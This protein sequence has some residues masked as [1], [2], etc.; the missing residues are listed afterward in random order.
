MSG[1]A[2]S[3]MPAN[4][5]GSREAPP[6]EA[7]LP[8]G[9]PEGARCLRG[10]DTEGAHYLV[11]VPAQW[12]GHLVVHAHGG[13]PLGDPKPTRVDEDVRRW[14]AMVRE[15]HAWAGSVFR[16]G[17]FAVRS[18]AEDTERVRRIFTEHVATPRRTLLHGQSWGAMVAAKAAEL[19][20]Q[21]WD[22]LLLSSGAVGGLLAYDF[23]LDL[24]A[25]YQYLCNNHPR[26]D[27]PAYPLSVGLRADDPMTEA[28]LAA[29][30]NEALGVD[31]PAARSAEQARRLRTIV[32]VLRIPEDGVADQL[33]WAT[34]TLRDV[35]EKHGGSPVGNEGVRYAGSDD[36]A[37]LNAGV[38][39]YRPDPAARERFAT[40]SDYVGRFA[41]PVL[42]VHGIHDTTCF[43]EVHDT[44]RQRMRAAGCEHQLVQTFVDSDQHSH[45]GEAIYPPLFEALLGWIESG[46]APTPQ[47]IAQ[48]SLSRD[49]AGGGGFVPDFVPGALAARIHPR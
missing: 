8:T 40:Q 39:R 19:F 38:P 16:E 11:V 41:M 25:V 43:V 45:L 13:P 35:V 10:R 44:L 27:E 5:I 7:P 49:A 15:G 14:A 37:A 46:V 42:T 2:A 31:L 34:F 29:R 6:V 12:S 17:G 33:R 48:R 24:R 20:P 23:R 21:S 18:A 36:D 32:E 1:E 26:P 22:G 4:P 28:E 9:L 30:V 47:Q 3:G